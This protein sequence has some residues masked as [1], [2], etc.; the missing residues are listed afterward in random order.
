MRVPMRQQ[1]APIFERSHEQSELTSDLTTVNDGDA[2]S[3]HALPSFSKCDVE[4]NHSA[5]GGLH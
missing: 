5:D 2:Q 4:R 3:L 1:L